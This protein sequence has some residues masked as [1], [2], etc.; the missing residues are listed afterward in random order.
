MIFTPQSG[1]QVGKLRDL[2]WEKLSEMFFFSDFSLFLS[3]L[4][5]YRSGRHS[6]G[7]KHPSAQSATYF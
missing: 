1:A 4:V 6:F 3:N 5:S 2:T 7:E